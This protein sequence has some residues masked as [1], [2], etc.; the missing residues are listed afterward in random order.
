LARIKA[1]Y[2][3]RKSKRIRLTGSIARVA[4]YQFRRVEIFEAGQIVR[5]GVITQIPLVP[6]VDVGRVAPREK[7]DFSAFFLQNA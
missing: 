2:E 5:E 6:E 1:D 7:R 3:G 4:S